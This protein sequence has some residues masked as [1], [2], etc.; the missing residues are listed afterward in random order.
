METTLSI[1]TQIS[2]RIIKE[3]EAIIG[4]LAWSE[5]A[6][7]D[8]LSVSKDLGQASVVGDPKTVINALVERYEKLFGKLSRE[9]CRE[10]VTDLTADI[11]SDEIPATLKQ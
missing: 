7:V 5:A 9:I 11:P 10:A 8:G 3:Q 1:F 2:L 4:P 6:K